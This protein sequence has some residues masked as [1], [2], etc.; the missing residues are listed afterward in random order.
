MSFVPKQLWEVDRQW[1]ECED[2]TMWMV[3]R[4]ECLFAGK[5]DDNEKYA[6]LNWYRPA[7]SKRVLEA[8]AKE[9]RCYLRWGTVSITVNTSAGFVATTTLVIVPLCKIEFLPETMPFVAVGREDVTFCEDNIG[10]FLKTDEFDRSKAAPYALRHKWLE[11]DLGWT[12]KGMG[13]IER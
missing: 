6:L 12:E 2:K 7:S 11:N 9:N 10:V 8:A 3:Y 13:R 5:G 1:T 4:V